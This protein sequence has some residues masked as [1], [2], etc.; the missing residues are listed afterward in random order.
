MTIPYA[1]LLKEFNRLVKDGHQEYCLDKT[2][3]GLRNAIA[4]RRISARQPGLPVWLLN[5]K[6]DRREKIY[7]AVA[8]EITREWLDN[9][10][11]RLFLEKDK[12]ISA[13]KAMGVKFL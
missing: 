3:I 4:H 8:E 5:F 1:G 7:V 10:V 9:Q 6:K 2:L 13:G 11:H 12:V